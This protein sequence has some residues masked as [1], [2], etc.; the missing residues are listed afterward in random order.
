MV[1]LDA[2]VNVAPIAVNDNNDG[3]AVIEAGLGFAGDATASSNV[4]YNDRDGNWRL[5][6]TMVVSGISGMSGGTV[7]VAV[8]GTYGSLLINANG[9]YTYT[10]NNADADTQA[11]VDGQLAAD[12]FI[13][14]VM[15]AHGATGSA[16]LSIMI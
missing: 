1:S 14:T 11:L 5:G 6:D 13:Y 12:Q 10:L 9:N 4:L 3:D 7:G 2:A 8:V 16:T 15:D